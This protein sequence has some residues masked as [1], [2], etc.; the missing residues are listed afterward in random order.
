MAGK[1]HIAMFVDFDN[2]Q[3][4]A[5]EMHFEHC[6]SS[7]LW[8]AP[9]VA[10]AEKVVTGS[11]DIR[12]CYGNVMLRTA[13]IF[14]DN[15]YNIHDVRERIKIDSDLQQDLLNNG[16]Q[17][18][19]TP[20]L[21]GKNRADILMSLDCMEV[22]MRYEMIDTFAIISH[23]SDFSPLVQS[24]RASGKQVIWISIGD[25]KRG[26]RILSLRAMATHHIAY[27]QG[28]IDAA[29]NTLLQEVLAD[30]R[31]ESEDSFERGVALSVL[32]ARLHSKSSSFRF[33]NLGF[34]NFKD[35]VE[36]CLDYPYVVQNNAV[37]IIHGNLYEIP[38]EQISVD[39][40]LRDVLSVEE[41]PD[42][43][44]FPALHSRIIKMYPN[45]NY[46]SLGYTKFKDFVEATLPI[47][48]RTT[49]EQIF[50][51][52]TNQRTSN[53]HSG[54]SAEINAVLNRQSLRQLPELRQLVTSW[55][56]ENLFEDEFPI[57][58]LTYGEIQESLVRHF[59][60]KSQVSKRQ[61]SDVLNTLLR[62]EVLVVENNPELPWTQRNV[63]QLLTDD[64]SLPRIA[65]SILQ[66][67]MAAGVSISESD[68]PLLAEI[69]FGSAGQTHI[70][71]IRESFDI[72]ADSELLEIDLGMG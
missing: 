67:L 56:T 38:M 11:V 43:I 4:A 28:L 27:D 3:S 13:R 45:F 2:A 35:F 61:I 47:N 55:L 64:S 20:D 58:T 36:S 14:A 49:G 42:G 33:G 65:Q 9:I 71:V 12:R 17:M 5:I 18:I 54:R 31:G 66:R 50:G 29:G 19:H 25:L 6:R 70:T 22:A 51:S 53:Q 68:F 39:T 16:F 57:K 52:S 46:K 23:D 37:H 21:S 41:I 40:I 44:V 34:V 24:L 32:N 62:S 59:T 60:S 72:V 69:V 63:Q 26:T 7:Q 15:S 30:I 1:S 8:M 48:Y 10:E